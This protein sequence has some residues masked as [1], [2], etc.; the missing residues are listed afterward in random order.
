[1][2][3]ESKIPIL[4]NFVEVIENMSAAS[5]STADAVIVT[6]TFTSNGGK[7]LILASGSGFKTGTGMTQMR[8][9]VDGVTVA[10]INKFFNIANQHQAFPTC[11]AITT[12]IAGMHTIRIINGAVDG[13]GVMNT[14]ANDRFYITIIKM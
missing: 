9:Q 12:V 2:I 10:P 11:F 13:S 6:S 5:T 7:I 8:L 14:D 1:M 4:N 3:I